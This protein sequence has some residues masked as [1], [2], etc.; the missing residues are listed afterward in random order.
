MF[1]CVVDGHTRPTMQCSYVME[2]ILMA[3][4]TSKA[5]VGG[6][7][8]ALDMSQKIENEGLPCNATNSSIALSPINAKFTKSTFVS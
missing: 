5:L 1:E 2:E 3:E 4:K 6:D 8:T 7:K